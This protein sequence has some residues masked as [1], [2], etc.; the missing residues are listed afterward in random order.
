MDPER[1]TF[2]SDGVAIAA[3]LYRPNQPLGIA[4]V[5]TGPMT[6]VKEQAAGAYAAALARRGL[7]A[8]VF[9]HRF[10]GE[11]GECLV[12]SNR[13]GTRLRISATP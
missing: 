2:E 4:V 3:N 8:L 10:F 11:S 12:N 1:V 6:S 7:T 9:D 5:I 13:R